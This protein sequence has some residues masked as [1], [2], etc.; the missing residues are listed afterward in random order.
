M[1]EIRTFDG[2]PA[3]LAEFCVSCWKAVYQGTDMPFLLWSGEFFDWELFGPRHSEREF[4]V[5]AYDGARL[6]GVLPARPVPVSLH[7]EPLNC[8]ICSYFSVDPEYRKTRAAAQLNI[9]SRRRHRDRGVDFMFGYVYTGASASKGAG[10]WLKQPKHVKVI[11][12]VGHWV[13]VLDPRAVARFDRHGLDRWGARLL[14]L[15]QRPVQPPRDGA[16]VRRYEPRDLAACQALARAMADECELSYIWETDL[17]ERQ[18]SYGDV[19]RTLVAEEDSRVTGFINYCH[20]GFRHIDDKGDSEIKVAV[21]DLLSIRQ[22]SRRMQKRLLQ[23]ALADMRAEGCHL[24]MMLRSPCHDWGPLLR[25]GFVMQP[26]AQYAF[27][28]V[29]TNG[30]EAPV[31]VRRL[32]VHWR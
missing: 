1:L 12:Q 27:T 25:R 15:V 31:G 20:L 13:R 14:G 7:G 9:E 32:H 21:I 18:I 28:M 2:S 22:A 17:F 3:E 4:V 16:G 11:R 8:T 29:E 24:A 6:V 23:Q 5:A 30:R 19:T 10:F 26:S